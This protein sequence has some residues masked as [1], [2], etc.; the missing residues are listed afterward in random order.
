[1]ARLDSGTYEGGPLVPAS[2]MCGR[3]INDYAQKNSIW[4]TLAL[5]RSHMLPIVLGILNRIVLSL[6]IISCSINNPLYVHPTR[7]F[8]HAH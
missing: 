3:I 7:L 5:L 1:M 4:S 8:L 6:S 2:D